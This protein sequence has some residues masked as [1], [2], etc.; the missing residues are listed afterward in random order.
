MNI[1]LI[2]YRAGNLTSVRKALG[3]VGAEVYTPEQADDLKNADGII[4]PGV[5]HFNVTATL[6]APWRE[7]VRTHVVTPESCNEGRVKS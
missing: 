7:A 3:A 4:V 2:D 1:A 6:D 5:G